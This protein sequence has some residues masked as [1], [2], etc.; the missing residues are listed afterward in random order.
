MA[1]LP[2]ALRYELSILQIIMDYYCICNYYDNNDDVEVVVLLAIVTLHN[3]RQTTWS[4]P[5][6][7]IIVLCSMFFLF[8]VLCTSVSFSATPPLFGN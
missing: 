2:V 4:I 3:F 6:T 8:S 5:I 1:T 7:L